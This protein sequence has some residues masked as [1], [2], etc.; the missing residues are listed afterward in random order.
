MKQCSKCKK[1]K[2][3]DEFY[4]DKTKKDHLSSRCKVCVKRAVDLYRTSEIGRANRLRFNNSKKGQIGNRR[5]S[6]RYK[7]GITEE[8]YNKIWLA[9]G[10]C[11]AICKAPYEMLTKK[12]PIDHDHKT[13]QIRGILCWKCNNALGSIG[14]DLQ[15][16]Q[17]CLN[18]LNKS[19]LSWDGYFIEHSKVVA[20]KSKDR[21]TKVGAVLVKSKRIIGTGFN[22]LPCGV[23]DTL[24]RYTSPDKYKWIVHAEENVLMNCAKEGVA[25]DG[26]T[27]YVSPLPPCSSCAKSIIQCGV[28]EVVYFSPFIPERWKDDTN[29]AKSILIEA[30]VKFRDYVPVA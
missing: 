7:Y 3:R 30:G 19:Y 20:N 23:K 14:D 17:R 15:S 2:V 10:K 21:S 28:K 29:F 6:L 25:V 5:R 8:D 1:S 26:S 13:G 22:G 12:F 16:I 24:E 18:Y 27:L 11:C 4:I 9:Q